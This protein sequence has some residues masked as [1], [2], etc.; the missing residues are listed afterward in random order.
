MAVLNQFTLYQ[1]ILAFGF[2]DL[3]ELEAKVYFILVLYRNHK[4]GT[5][6][7][8]KI[9]V[10]NHLYRDDSRTS[11]SGLTRAF[12]GLEL[13]GRIKRVAVRSRGVIEYF[14]LD[15]ISSNRCTPMASGD[16]HRSE[17]QP[18]PM[19]DG[20]PT[21]TMGVQTL[22]GTSEE[23]IIYLP[24]DEKETPA[25]SLR[26]KAK[27][28]YSEPFSRW[29]KAFPRCAAKDA[30][31]RAECWPIWKRENLDKRIDEIMDGM[32]YWIQSKSW[33]EGFAKSPKWFLENEKWTEQPSPPKVDPNDPDTWEENQ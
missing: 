14:I 6:W 10:R 16:L 5:S 13:K 22:D 23:Q 20:L 30:S 33:R 1:R 18:T 4:S 11:T 19:N 3:L 17:A 24:D 9:T 25:A 32:E 7:P 12:S 29:W 2:A 15:P 26:P 31:S 21:P 8:S 27:T 28:P